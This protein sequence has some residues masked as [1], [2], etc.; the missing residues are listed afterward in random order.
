MC[1]SNMANRHIKIGEVVPFT[2]KQNSSGSEK[3]SPE[4]T[5]AWVSIQCVSAN[6]TT[7]KWLCVRILM[8]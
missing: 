6:F 8:L 3:S 2:I 7:I 1:G 5:K 4:V